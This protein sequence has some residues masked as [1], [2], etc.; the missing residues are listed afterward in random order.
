M[1]TLK[2]PKWGIK[3]LG[4]LFYFSV[5]VKYWPSETRKDLPWEP[6]AIVAGCWFVSHLLLLVDRVVECGNTSKSM[7]ISEV[8]EACNCR[9]LI[10]GVQIYFDLGF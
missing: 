9:E 7:A 5:S 10:S 3:W 6:P 1:Y 8:D 2:I 4:I